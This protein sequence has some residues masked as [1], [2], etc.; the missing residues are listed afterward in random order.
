MLL[1]HALP[2]HHR[3]SQSRADKC[4]AFLM[5]TRL[6]W[7]PHWMPSSTHIVQFVPA[8]SAEIPA[9]IYRVASPSVKFAIGVDA[10]MPVEA[11][12]KTYLSVW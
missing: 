4:F 6:T 10:S 5:K 9:I 2:L 1:Q 7:P 12:Y 8:L 3:R 11:R